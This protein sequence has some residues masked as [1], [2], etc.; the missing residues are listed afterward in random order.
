MCVCVCVSI[1]SGDQT[2]SVQSGLDCHYRINQLTHT[3]EMVTNTHIGALILWPLD[4]TRAQTHEDTDTY[5]S[6]VLHT[7]TLALWHCFLFFYKFTASIQTHPRSVFLSCWTV[8]VLRPLRK[9]LH[10]NV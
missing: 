9:L 5:I 3:N 4:R 1:C 7:D 10:V 8:K 2:V 6:S